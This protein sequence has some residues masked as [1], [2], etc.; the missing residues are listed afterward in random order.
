MVDTKGELN[1]P[2]L[3]VSAVREIKS[4][5][6]FTPL[7][8]FIGDEEL[9]TSDAT[10]AAIRP[11]TVE[12]A[13]VAYF[14]DTTGEVG[15]GYTADKFKLFITQVEGRPEG[16][17]AV[18]DRHLYVATTEQ[19]LYALDRNDGTVVW[20]RRLAREPDGPPIV[21]QQNLYIGLR[22]GGME[23][24]DLG[25][26][27]PEVTPLNDCRMF[28]A[29]W[30]AR[31]AMLDNEGRVALFHKQTWTRAATLEPGRFDLAISNP[32]NDAV[33][34]GTKRGELLCIRPANSLPLPVDAFLSEDMKKAMAHLAEIRKQEAAQ[35]QKEEAKQKEVEETNA[36]AGPPDNAPA[37]APVPERIEDRL[38]ADPLRSHS[39]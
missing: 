35:K 13:E 26:E 31:V 39:P 17:L 22:G 30:P 27:F 19:W 6:S 21:A 29:D 8:A 34:V 14:A 12:F 18:D 28:L 11:P 4:K 38:L 33:F 3:V 20:Q 37:E 23:R 1:L 16:G 24:F 32:L 15:A 9:R 5:Y 25:G 2:P 10:A 36:A 7:E